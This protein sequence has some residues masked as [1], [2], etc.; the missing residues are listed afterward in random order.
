MADNNNNR[1]LLIAIGVLTVVFFCACMV[2]GIII[3]ATVMI[4][5]NDLMNE[6]GGFIIA[7]VLAWGTAAVIAAVL[8]F[9]V[10]VIGYVLQSIQIAKEQNNDL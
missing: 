2:F 9:V 6:E 5:A 7:T 4:V 3:Q 1:S 8:T 10:G